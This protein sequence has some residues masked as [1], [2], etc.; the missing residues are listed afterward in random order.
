MAWNLQSDRPIYAQLVDQIQRMIVTGIFPAG[1]RLPSVREL[2]A[3]AAVNPNT[4]QRALVKL[5]ED[6]LLYTQRT[7][8]RYVT[9]ETE[10]ILEVKR[11]LAEELIRQ[12]VENMN[13]LG[14]TREQ[15]VELLK[16]EEEKNAKSD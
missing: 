16:K 5:E 6:G 8:G 4:M 13:R 7:S 15:S 10:R 12:F 9:E 14:Y 1:S 2:A 11:A 3:E